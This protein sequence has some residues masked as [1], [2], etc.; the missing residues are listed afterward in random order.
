L[1]NP[2]FGP[3]LAVWGAAVAG[4]EGGTAAWGAA[5]AGW[6]GGTAVWGAA[7]VELATG[8]IWPVS[9]M[10]ELAGAQ[11]ARTRQTMLNTKSFFIIE[12]SY[13]QFFSFIK[14]KESSD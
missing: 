2:P 8:P 11:L 6:E 13:L 14:K 5:V 10:E 3:A 9:P 4:W 1:G 7:A 12:S